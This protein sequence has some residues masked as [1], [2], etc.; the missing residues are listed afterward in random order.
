MNQDIKDRIIE[1]RNQGNGYRQIGSQIGL[2]REKV[3]DFL[4]TKTAQEKLNPN[5]KLITTQRIKIKL[6]TCKFCGKQYQLKDSEMLSTVYCS[7]DCKL[8]QKEKVKSE[9]IPKVRTSIC[10]NCGK[11]FENKTS[12]VYCSDECRHI[13]KTCV[14]CGKKFITQMH[15]QKKYCSKECKKSN[16]MKSHEDYC[17]EILNIHH[18]NLLPITLYNG[19]GNDITMHCLLC[20]KQTT[21]IADKFTNRKQGCSHC[22]R[23]VSSAEDEIA[24]YLKDKGIEY[25]SQYRFI[26]TDIQDYR[27]DFAIIEEDKVKL[28]IEYDGI[29]H[30]KPVDI[31]GGQ[32]E[33]LSRK[34]RDK[35]KSRYAKVNRIP[36]IRINHHQR[37]IIK[38]VLSGII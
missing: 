12:A 9:F 27:Y 3:R 19:S 38:E 2:T 5:I 8:K 10:K 37:N 26:G 31:F 35:A 16:I 34:T 25:I 33:Y 22:G 15:N 28:L 7:I 29:Q 20:G 17:R 11:E 13:E 1:L 23:R 32:E 4:R 18:G 30:T 24:E 21:R 6:I 14:C 36:L